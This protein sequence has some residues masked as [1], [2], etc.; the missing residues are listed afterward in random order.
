MLKRLLHI[1]KRAHKSFFL[2]GPRGTGKTS[3]VKK[4]FSEALYLDLLKNRDY[5]L[6]QNDPSRLEKLV[7]SHHSPWTVI[8]EVQ[9]IPALL[10]VVHRLIE[11]HQQCFVLTGSSSRKLKQ[12][13]VN[14]LA[15]RAL[16]YHM[17]P[18]TCCEIG[19]AFDIKSALQKGLLPAILTEK[20]PKAFLESYVA[21]YLREEV[22]QEGLVRNAGSFSRFME[23]ASFSQGSPLNLSNIAREVGVS[24]KIVTAYFDI[25]TD[26]LI[27]DQV[28]CFTKRAQRKMV[29]HPKFYYFDTGVY[30]NI[31][32][33][34]PLDTPEEITGS[35][36]ETLFYQHLRAYID[37][38][39]LDLSI[40]FWRTAAGAEVDFI[41][42]GEKGI[43]AFELKSKKAITR[44]NFSGLKAFKKDYP[45]SQC[46]LIYTGE[47]KEKYDENLL[48]LPLQPALYELPHLLNPAVEPRDDETSQTIE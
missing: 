36:L 10:D 3:W 24:R 23:I 48:A 39:K 6:L 1:N 13:G 18:L 9:K 7:L 11:N 32:P 26:L 17:H 21:T 31:R 33:R 8:D 37:Y 46:Y 38:Y 4:Y 28:P 29:Q 45:M 5:I 12:K 25:L 34:G 41:V 43:F 15:G 22:I 27:A 20:D 30:Q 14:L 16:T 47:H 44:K 40:Y 19:E 35:A 2:F 42:Y